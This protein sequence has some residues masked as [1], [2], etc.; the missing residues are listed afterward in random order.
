MIYNTLYTSYPH[1]IHIYPQVMHII[2]KNV[3]ITLSKGGYPL[4]QMSYIGPYS[5]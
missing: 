5:V 2:D 1:S 4:D 3:T